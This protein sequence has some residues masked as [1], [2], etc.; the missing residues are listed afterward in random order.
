MRLFLRVFFHCIKSASFLCILFLLCVE[1][2]WES[3]NS[4]FWFAHFCL[5]WPYTLS[6]RNLIVT[7]R[8][9]TVRPF[10]R[11]QKLCWNVKNKGSFD[12]AKTKKPNFL[13]IFGKIIKMFL[14]IV[15]SI[16]NIFVIFLAPVD[17]SKC[18]DSETTPFFESNLILRW[19]NWPR[20]KNGTNFWSN[21]TIFFGFFCHC[22]HIFHF[23]RVF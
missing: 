15:T 13:V 20:S 19:F 6:Y 12:V 7:G 18:V 17:R 14:L 16:F 11:T 22:G 9:R 10:C 4:D 3:L 1:S 2:V 23:L 5:P 8:F 21:R